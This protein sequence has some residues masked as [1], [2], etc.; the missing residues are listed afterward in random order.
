MKQS[1]WYVLP[2]VSFMKFF[3]AQNGEKFLTTRLVTPLKD[4]RKEK[5]EKK[6]VTYEF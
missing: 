1:P 6:L 2:L 4:L 3:L 5:R